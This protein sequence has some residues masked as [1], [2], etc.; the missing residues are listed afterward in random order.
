MIGGGSINEKHRCKNNLTNVTMT[1][2]TGVKNVEEE[3]HVEMN[4]D[5]RNYFDPENIPAHLFHALMGLDRCPNYL[6]RVCGDCQRLP[7]CLQ[8]WF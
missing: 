7:I 6:S 8:N 3:S 5:K 2:H 1:D 4:V